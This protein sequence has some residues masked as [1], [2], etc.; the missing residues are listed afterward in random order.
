MKNH[1]LTIKLGFGLAHNNE[2]LNNRLAKLNFVRDVYTRCRLQ[3]I[4]DVKERAHFNI[5]ANDFDANF[6]ITAYYSGAS[7]N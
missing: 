1:S 4:N 5:G 3:E 6:R 7:Y 2:N